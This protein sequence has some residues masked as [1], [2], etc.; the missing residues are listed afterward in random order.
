M[1]FA[2]FIGYIP[3]FKSLLIIASTVINYKKIL[4]LIIAKLIE[5]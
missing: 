1:Q 5:Q 3:S 2:C 4:G